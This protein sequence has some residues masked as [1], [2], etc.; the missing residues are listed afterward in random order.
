M[1]IV[2]PLGTTHNPHIC[3][4]RHTSEPSSIEMRSTPET[5]ES[6]EAFALRAFSLPVFF[7]A[8]WN[9]H[10]DLNIPGPL[11]FYVAGDE[12]R[13]HNGTLRHAF[14]S[15]VLFIALWIDSISNAII[16]YLLW[17]R[18]IVMYME[19]LQC[20]VEYPP[21]GS[22]WRQQTNNLLMLCKRQVWIVYSAI[23][24]KMRERE[25]QR[26]NW[27]DSTV[28]WVQAREVEVSPPPIAFYSI[29]TSNFLPRTSL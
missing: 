14:R 20:S 18:S 16:Q 28:S 25:N 21:F 22:V 1:K 10:F 29:W 12:T 19:M 23:S 9:I 7:G 8:K 15:H 4:Y 5:F 13:P 3:T 24:A 2:T 11:W 26:K 27:N 6:H 17:W